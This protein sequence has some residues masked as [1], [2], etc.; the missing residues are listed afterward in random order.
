MNSSNRGDV[1]QTRR[2]NGISTKTSSKP[3]MLDT[4]VRWSTTMFSGYLQA[5]N[6]EYN[7]EGIQEVEEVGDSYC[8][9]Y[10]DAKNTGPIKESACIQYC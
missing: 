9:A 1:G 6:R 8:Y 10:D 4:T 7:V 3:E 5:Q 2:R